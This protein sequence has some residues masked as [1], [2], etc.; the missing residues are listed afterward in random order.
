MAY[1]IKLIFFLIISMYLISCTEKISYSGKILEEKID[2]NKIKNKQQLINILGYPNFVDPI[3]NNYFY[4][5][6]K[7]ITKNFYNSKIDFRNVIKFEINNDDQIKLISSF[8]IKDE[9]ILIIEK[10]KTKNNLIKRGLIERVFGGIG[11]QSI[12][13]TP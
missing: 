9:K 10:E 12:P 8:K 7:I 5:T 11:K 3:E 1:F 13:N 4:F 6:Q 2:Y